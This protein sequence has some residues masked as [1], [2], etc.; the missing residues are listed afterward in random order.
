MMRA[1]T[2]APAGLRTGP[3]AGPCTQTDE[4]TSRSRAWS[5]WP[6]VVRRE[7]D[8]RFVGVAKRLDS[9]G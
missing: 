8:D 1:K 2:A 9:E 4:P 3:A 5:G 7:N 6:R